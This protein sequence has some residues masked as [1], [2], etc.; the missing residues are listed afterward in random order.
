MHFM[1]THPFRSSD[2]IH[3]S[4]DL[5]TRQG[6]AVDPGELALFEAADAFHLEL[7][8]QYPWYGWLHSAASI[9]K[10]ASLRWLDDHPS[11]P[12]MFDGVVAGSR[13]LPYLARAFMVTCA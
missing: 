9:L 3:C 2:R 12:P 10:A 4:W 6:Q 8:Q 13:I 11:R 7:R 1:M 5:L